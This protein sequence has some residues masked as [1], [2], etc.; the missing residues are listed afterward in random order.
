MVINQ[1]KQIEKVYL[2]YLV[3]N[4]FIPFSEKNIL[5]PMILIVQL[6]AS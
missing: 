2:K 5:Y 1:L 6:V 4:L 3:F